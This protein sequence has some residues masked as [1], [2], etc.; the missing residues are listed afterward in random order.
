MDDPVIRMYIVYASFKI[1]DERKARF[2][3]EERRGRYRKLM[4]YN[5]VFI[6]GKHTSYLMHILSTVG[7]LRRSEDLRGGKGDTV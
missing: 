7:I 2:L 4:V 1:T 6:P 3:R 5:Y